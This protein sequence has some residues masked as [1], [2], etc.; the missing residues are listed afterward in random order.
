MCE[1]SVYGLCLTTLWGNLGVYQSTWTPLH[2]WTLEPE[3]FHKM[4]YKSVSN[5][6]ICVQNIHS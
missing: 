5:L 3:K 2:Q 6:C 4:C 1:S